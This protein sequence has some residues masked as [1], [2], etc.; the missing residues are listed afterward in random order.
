MGAVRLVI[1]DADYHRVVTAVR[2]AMGDSE[3]DTR[4]L[5]VQHCRPKKRPPTRNAAPV[6]QAT[7]E[8]LGI[9]HADRTR[10]CLTRRR[11]HTEQ[12]TSPPG[13]SSRR[14]PCSR[15]CATSTTSSN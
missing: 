2:N 14:E 5:R 9:A 10:Y 1:W 3:F 12:G 8:R 6:T 11:G 13:S 4:G 7:V 15:I